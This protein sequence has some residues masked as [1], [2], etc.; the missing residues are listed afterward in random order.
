MTME[1][2][3]KGVEEWPTPALALGPKIN[4]CKKQTNK[5]TSHSMLTWHIDSGFKR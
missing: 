4:S 1:K 3:C 2:A 5:K